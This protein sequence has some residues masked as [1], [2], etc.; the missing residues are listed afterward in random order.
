MAL[1]FVSHGLSVVRMMCDNPVPVQRGRVME[2]G[3]GRATFEAPRAAYTCIPLDTVGHFD[4]H[5]TPVTACT[6]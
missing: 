6:A 5:G 4:P 3:P 1:L 2:A